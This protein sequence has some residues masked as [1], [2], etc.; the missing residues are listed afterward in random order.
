LFLLSLCL[1]A[2]V[3][4]AFLVEAAAIDLDGTLLDSLPDIA[5]AAQRM[6]HDL[7]RPAAGLQAVRGY[8]GGGIARLVHRLLTGTMDG[9]ADP[10]E[11]ERALASFERHYRDTFLTNPQPFPNAVEGLAGMRAAG[12][13]LAC[14]TNKPA[15]F[16]EPLLAAVGI[17]GHFDLV[18]S[19]DSL[20]ARK[21]DPL[22]LLHVAACFGVAPARLLVIGDS[23][24]D[25]RAA[26]AAGCPV[27][28]VPYGYRGGGEVRDL[29]CDAIVA[30]LLEA[31]RLMA[32]PG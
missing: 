27:V 29:D 22:P 11:F 30:D 18:V 21:P 17:A 14:I 1:R 5:E 23:D 20:P 26:R 24:N 13:K 12:L 15:A 19:G 31:S 25:T 32:T 28:C 9:N 6:L 4:R 2:S 8:V 7:G 16:T 3:V 10:A